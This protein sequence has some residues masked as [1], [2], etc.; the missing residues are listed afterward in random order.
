MCLAR[1]AYVRGSCFIFSSPSPVYPNGVL[2][3]KGLGWGEW[4]GGIIELYISESGPDT[5]L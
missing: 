1:E 5:V 2:F 3:D 4:S